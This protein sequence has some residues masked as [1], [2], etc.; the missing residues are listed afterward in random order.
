MRS[1]FFAFFGILTLSLISSASADSLPCSKL[2]VELRIREASFQLRN[3]TDSEMIRVTLPAVTLQENCAQSVGV[4]LSHLRYT[5]FF[6]PEAPAGLLSQ[7]STTASRSI[8]LVALEASATLSKTAVSMGFSESDYPYFYWIY[9]RAQDRI[10]EI[11][12][13]LAVVAAQQGN[14]TWVRVINRA[15]TQ[16]GASRSVELIRGAQLVY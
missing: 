8:S 10:F 7:S 2:P 13:P 4:D 1:S 16:G 3:P 9:D 14:Q 6:A 12:L 15:Y 11:Y 5:I